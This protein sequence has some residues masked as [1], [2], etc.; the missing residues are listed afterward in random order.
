M[1]TKTKMSKGGKSD[2]DDGEDAAWV[3]LVTVEPSKLKNTDTIKN[4]HTAVLDLGSMANNNKNM[5]DFDMFDD[6]ASQVI[7]ATTNSAEGNYNATNTIPHVFSDSDTKILVKIPDIPTKPKKPHKNKNKNKNKKKS[8]QKKMVGKQAAVS[9]EATDS[10]RRD[11]DGDSSESSPGNNSSTGGTNNSN[12]HQRGGMN[13]KLNQWNDEQCPGQ[14]GGDSD[15]TD[16]DDFQELSIHFSFRDIPKHK[17]GTVLTAFI[18]TSMTKDNSLVFHPT[19]RQTLSTPKPF[20]TAETIPSTTDTVLE[21]F[22]MSIQP[23]GMNIYFKV[24]STFTIMKIR[25]RVLPFM[26]NNKLWMNNKQIDDN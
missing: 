20:R 18:S 19:N 14:L 8:T 25:H 2:N 24:K 15:E 21:F 22:H 6:D 7:V 12:V 4:S 26:K 16:L 10:S 17:V 3:P 1:S 23:K 5:P 13:D 9:D 11:C